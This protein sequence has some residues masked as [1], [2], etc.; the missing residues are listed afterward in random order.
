MSELLFCTPI[1][2]FV[3]SVVLGLVVS[4]VIGSFLSFFILFA[5]KTVEGQS[6]ENA[7]S[8]VFRVYVAVFL[9]AAFGIHLF[10]LQKYRNWRRK[11]PIEVIK[12]RPAFCAGLAVVFMIL[13]LFPS[14]TETKSDSFEYA[15][16]P[17]V[18][19]SY[20]GW[21]AFFVVRRDEHGKKETIWSRSFLL[22]N[23][24]I[25]VLGMA[26]VLAFDKSS[27]SEEEIA[28]QKKDDEKPDDS[29]DKD[30]RDGPDDPD[31][32]QDPPSPP[33]EDTPALRKSLSK[34]SSSPQTLELD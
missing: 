27:L 18:R 11:P 1:R 29:D 19:E 22:V 8:T 9:L 33:A 26:N 24:L 2:R 4:F 20:Y 17:Y 34:E 28:K 7:A 31:G 21:P 6:H 3:S 5:A 23:A 13:S 25:L 16:N 10:G 14:T 32:P 15:D 12:P 30:D